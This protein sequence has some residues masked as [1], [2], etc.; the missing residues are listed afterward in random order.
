MTILDDLA[1]VHGLV[2]G[3]ACQRAFDVGQPREHLASTV[4][5]GGLFRLN[6]FKCSTIRLSLVSVMAWPSAIRDITTGFSVNR[7]FVGADRS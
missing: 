5:R 2:A 6:F 4:S 3:D 1:V 7:A